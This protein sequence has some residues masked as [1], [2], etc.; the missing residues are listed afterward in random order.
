MS[1]T[2]KMTLQKEQVE[3]LGN[4]FER[5]GEELEIGYEKKR[6]KTLATEMKS[7]LKKDWFKDHKYTLLEYYDPTDID[8]IY[9]AEGILWKGEPNPF[10]TTEG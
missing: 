2:F 5:L 3:E 10:I 9:Y 8:L 6:A 4:F 7:I 1:D